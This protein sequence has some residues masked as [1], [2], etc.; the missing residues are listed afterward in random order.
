MWDFPW[1]T[2]REWAFSLFQDTLEIT[3]AGMGVGARAQVSKTVLRIRWKSSLEYLG[4]SVAET[5]VTGGFAPK[6][7][8]G[9]LE[10]FDSE[11]GEEL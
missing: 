7:P 4:I 9:Y 2:S 10:N 8:T 5:T 1:Y 11:G 3:G 6:D